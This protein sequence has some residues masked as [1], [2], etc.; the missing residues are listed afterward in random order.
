MK[1]INLVGGLSK[2]YSIIL[3]QCDTDIRYVGEFDLKKVPDIHGRGGTCFD[4]PIK[5]AN[6]DKKCKAIIYFTDTEGDLNIAP[7]KP[8]YWVTDSDR[9]DHLTKF[10]KSFIIKLEV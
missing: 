3:I 10:D 8:V 9:T 7:L 6:E 1:Y 5:L 4:P 2:K